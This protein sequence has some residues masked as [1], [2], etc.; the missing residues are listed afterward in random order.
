VATIARD[1]MFTA[2]VGGGET[3]QAI[4]SQMGVCRQAV[5]ASVKRYRERCAG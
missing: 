1:E 5:L 2:L 4:A 3:F